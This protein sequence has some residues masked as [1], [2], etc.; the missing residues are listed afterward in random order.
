MTQNQNLSRTKK[1][2]TVAI[3]IAVATVL[4][5]IKLVDLPHGGSITIASMLPIIIISYKYGTGWGL[6]AGFIFGVIQQLTGLNTLTYVTTWQSVIAVILL[7]YIIAYAVIGLAG[8]FRKTIKNQTAAI[9]CG[10]IFVCILRYAC[11]VI[12]GATVWV[13]LSIPDTAALIYSFGYNATYMVP[14]TIVL[15][16]VGYYFSSMIDLSKDGDF[17]VQKKK[18]SMIPLPFSVSGGLVLAAALI[19]DTVEIFYNLQ[20]PETGEFDI[21]LL[22]NVAWL[23]VGIVTAVAAIAAIILFVIGKV[24][25][26]TKEKESK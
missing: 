17:A 18:E 25:K 14:E 12:S 21:T 8:I 26:K 3:L 4:S 5:L 20:N 19:Y 1:L 2:V 22:S 10:T 24:I 11:H 23:Y 15:I 13:G 16:I 7:D 6:A 9:I